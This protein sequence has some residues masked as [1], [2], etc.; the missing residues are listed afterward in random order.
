M[1]NNV[2]YLNGEVI[3]RKFIDG[4][5]CYISQKSKKK[6]IFGKCSR[7]IKS[8]NFHYNGSFYYIEGLPNIKFKSFEL[9]RGE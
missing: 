8:F 2:R 9:L 1:N 6:D 7:K 3:R 4:E 5:K